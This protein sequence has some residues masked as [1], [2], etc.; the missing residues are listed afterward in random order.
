MREMVTKVVV[1][2][3]R[4]LLVYRSTDHPSHK[5]KIKTKIKTKIITLHYI[6][7]IDY[8]N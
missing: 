4:T 6:D 5:G 3:K 1:T 2:S 8:T 7:V